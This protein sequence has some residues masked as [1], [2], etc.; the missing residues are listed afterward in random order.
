MGL[1]VSFWLTSV[2]DDPVPNIAAFTVVIFLYTCGAQT[3]P[4]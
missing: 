2:A 1:L 4:E 3:K